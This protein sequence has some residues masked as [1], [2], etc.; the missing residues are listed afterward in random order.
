[1]VRHAMLYFKAKFVILDEPTIALSLKEAEQVP[2]FMRQLKREGISVIHIT[3]NLHHVFLDA[4]RFVVLSR[5]KKVTD[6]RKEDTSI[7]ELSEL[8]IR[9]AS[10][11]D[12]QD[13]EGPGRRG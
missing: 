12:T 2:N 10:S 6:V 3:H 8:I 5:G 13:I 11:Q 4:D 7:E 1:M 9:G